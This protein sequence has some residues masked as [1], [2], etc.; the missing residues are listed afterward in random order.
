MAPSLPNSDKYII[1]EQMFVV[2][3]LF[4]YLPYSCAL[5]HSRNR[6]N[7]AKWSIPNETPM[8]QTCMGVLLGF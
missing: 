4:A 2:K 5:F 7:T 3:P 8:Q 1:D 6:Q